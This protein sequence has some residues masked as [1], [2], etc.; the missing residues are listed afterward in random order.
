LSIERLATVLVAELSD[1]LRLSDF[2]ELLVA[3][4]LLLLALL[5]AAENCADLSAEADAASSPDLEEDA[6]VAKLSVLAALASKLLFEA[7]SALPDNDAELELVFVAVLELLPVALPEIAPSDAVALSVAE[8][9]VPE[10]LPPLAEVLLD[11][12]LPF[13]SAV[14][15]APAAARFAVKPLADVLLLPFALSAAAVI[16]PEA[17][18][19]LLAVNEAFSERSFVVPLDLVESKDADCEPVTEALV[20][21]PTSFVLFLVAS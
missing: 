4:M 1:E 18:F 9:T 5:E 20:I 16:V 17:D 10:V 7:R 6:V 11:V 14:P 8:P 19:D 13:E 2:A 21:A 15:F 3:V 12:G